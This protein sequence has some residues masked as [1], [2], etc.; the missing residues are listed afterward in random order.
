MTVIWG[1]RMPDC[2]FCRRLGR[3]CPDHEEDA[4]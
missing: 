3:R 4:A 1:D 2:E